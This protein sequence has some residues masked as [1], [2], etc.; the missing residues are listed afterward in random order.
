[1][2]DTTRTSRC[3]TVTPDVLGPQEMSALTDEQLVQCV[4]SRHPLALAEIVSR[5]GSVMAAVATRAVGDGGS[6]VV[7][8][9]FARLWQ[10]PGLFNGSRGPLRS[11]LILQ[12]R[13]RA[14][15]VVRTET[16]RRAREERD[17]IS[18]P[19]CSEEASVLGM[20]YS[21][22]TLGN[23]L[24]GL[25]PDERRPISLAFFEGY[26]YREVASMLDLPEGTI[27]SR[28]RS[29]LQRLRD[30]LAASVSPDTAT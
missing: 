24:D 18:E 12:V 30:G 8:D 4:A 1:M 16:A 2:T 25:A 9:V 23:L 5:H 21:H 6:D 26:T 28:I 22:E 10:R 3:P 20:L 7:Q 27:K 14:I 29:G 13:S 11:F 19:R 17:V 15:D